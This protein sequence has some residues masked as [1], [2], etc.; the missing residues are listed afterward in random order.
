MMMMMGHA[1][2]ANDNYQRINSIMIST[3]GK[4]SCFILEM[5]STR[6]YL[7]I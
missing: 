4:S 1:E 2:R 5:N 6:I 7:L 3:E